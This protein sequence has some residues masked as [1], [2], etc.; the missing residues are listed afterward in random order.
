MAAK[1]CKKMY[2][3]IKTFSKKPIR[4]HRSSVRDLNYDFYS[5]SYV[6]HCKTAEYT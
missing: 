6:L 2:G 4:A 5:K 3:E 1:S